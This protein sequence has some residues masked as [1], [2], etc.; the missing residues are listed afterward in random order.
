M[1]M[2]ASLRRP[3]LTT[4][5][6]NDLR[7]APSRV[8]RLALL[9]LLVLYVA[10]PGQ[11]TDFHL[12]ILNTAGIFAIGAIGLN[13]LTG[14]A[15]Q[16][17]LGHAFFLAV[18]AYSWAH[19]GHALDLPLPVWVVA[20][21]ITGALVG[22]L[23][24]PF[25]LRLR[26]NYLAIVSLGLVF[27]GTYVWNNF[28]SVTGGSRGVGGNRAA[29]IGGLDFSALELGGKVYTKDQGYFWMIWAIVAITVVLVK[30]VVR[31]RPGRALQAV[32]DRDVAA[33]VI[34]IDLKRYKVAAF[35]MSSAL[36][37]VAGSL[38]GSYRNFLAPDE[39]TLLLSIQF[40]AM[41]IVG[42]VGTIFGSILGALFIAGA[43]PLIE[44][45]GSNIPGL[46]WLTEQAGL[47]TSSLNQLIFGLVVII[48]L[49][50]EPHGLAGIWFRLKSYFRAW[51]FSY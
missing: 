29:T 47:S 20:A 21:G 4:A 31:T 26:G 13:V 8:T 40:I 23:V 27:I 22:A 18:G 2:L 32:R 10:V 17:S 51:P 28:E 9:A 5:Y 33:A 15:G 14:F 34:G 7:L 6:A 24:G 12:S 16:V 41:I 44:E 38:L 3:R 1:S 36:A 42:G 48:F 45:Y 19:F 11:L 39:W 49:I 35:A 30:N 46:E 43:P 37:A 25:A 50:L